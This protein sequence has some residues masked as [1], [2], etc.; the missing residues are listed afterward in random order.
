MTIPEH[1][2]SRYPHRVR[3]NV[4]LL[5]CAF[6][7]G[8]AFTA[9]RSGMQWLGPFLFNGLRE[10]LGVLT[11][12]LI[13]VCVYLGTRLRC[14]VDL[15]DFLLEADFLEQAARRRKVS[16]KRAARPL[17]CRHLLIGGVITGVVLCFASNLQQVGLVYTAAGKGAFI[18]AMYIVLV[19][20]AGLFLRRHIR[21]TSWLAVGLAVVGLYLLCVTSGFG[22]SLGDLLLIGCALGWT[23][24]ILVVDRYVQGLSW[25]GTLVFSGISFAV[26]G[27][28]SFC[29][30]PFDHFFSAATPTLGH[31][32]Q[33]APELLYAGVVSSGIAFTLQAVGQKYAP[34]QIASILM[35]LE[36]AFGLLGGAVLLGERLL[37]PQLAGCALMLLAVVLAQVDFKGRRRNLR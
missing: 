34:P 30:V 24:H 36:S 20:L 12:I 19:P 26:C 32:L 23:G 21:W 16:K 35:S 4:T 17:L 9:Q 5:F 2:P 18:T 31:L 7:W 8:M 37:L 3:G 33:V 25:Q 11:L 13:I 29:G 1:T 28:L 14:R 10:W 27:L 15:A 6:L 22:V